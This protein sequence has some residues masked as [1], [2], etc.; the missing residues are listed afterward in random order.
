MSGNIEGPPVEDVLGALADPTRRQIL[1]RLAGSGEATA[2]TL[3]AEM[4]VSRQA[5]VQHLA[6]LEA[7]GLVKG[8]RIGR[9]RRFIVVPR[10]L[11]E[12]ARWMDRLA[13]QWDGR[14]AAIKRIAEQAH[15]AGL[16]SPGRQKENEQPETDRS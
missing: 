15:Q 16:E 13:A 6:I 2:T 7:A 1:D 12:T 11:T 4:S 14:L 5:V 8:Y 9:E 10:R 3:T